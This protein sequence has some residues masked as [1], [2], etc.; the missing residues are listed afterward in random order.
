LFHKAKNIEERGF[1]RAVFA[2]KY[3]K[4]PDILYV[5]IFE[6]PVVFNVYVFDLHGSA[7][8]VLPRTGAPGFLPDGDSAGHPR[9]AWLTGVF[10]PAALPG[11]PESSIA[12]DR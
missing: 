11:A 4:L 10:R 2:E 6:R 12:Q 3:R 7:S 8:S 5:N 9:G 1:S